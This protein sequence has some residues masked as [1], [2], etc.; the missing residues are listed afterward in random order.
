MGGEDEPRPPG[1][2][3]LT[4][5]VVVSTAW[6]AGSASRKRERI[7][8]PEGPLG[9]PTRDLFVSEEIYSREDVTLSVLSPT[10][11]TEHFLSVRYKNM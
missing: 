5:T 1:V 4:A 3:H 9:C 8:P 11:V 10:S 6:V 7:S 2:R